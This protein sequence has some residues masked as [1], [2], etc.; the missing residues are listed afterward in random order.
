MMGLTLALG[1]V[2][3]AAA[4]CG[5]SVRVGSDVLWTARF[6]DGTFDELTLG[7]TGS[8]DATPPNTVEVSGERVHNGVFAA[9]LSLTTAMAGV[10][11]SASLSL[12]EGLPVEGFY[13]AWYYLPRSVTV[14]TFWVITKLRLRRVVDDPTSSDELYDLDLVSLASG[15]MSLALYDHRTGDVPLD[16]PDPIVPVGTWFHV[17]TYYRNAQDATGRVTYWLDGRQIV[18][19]AGKAM[20]PTPWVGWNACSIGED[21]SPSTAVLYIDDAAVSR[22]RVGPTGV[23][24]D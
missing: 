17:E 23:I 11:S 16:T 13:S 6:E 3:A 8:A 19:I 22:T 4:G 2:V 21:L 20:A 7:A 24:A 12:K 10:Q 1:L 18:D 5:E 14:G 15:E 9:K